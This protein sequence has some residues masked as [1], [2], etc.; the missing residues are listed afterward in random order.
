VDE[1]VDAI[2]EIDMWQCIKYAW[3]YWKICIYIVSTRED[4]P[5]C[6]ICE[7]CISIGSCN[8]KNRFCV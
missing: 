6:K 5:F 7:E 1:S 8:P 3:N 2:Q 4:L